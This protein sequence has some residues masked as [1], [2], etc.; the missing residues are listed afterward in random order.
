MILVRIPGKAR[1]RV[2]LSFQEGVQR[3][4]EMKQLV[5]MAWLA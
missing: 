5:E 4:R 3:V 2:I 1:V